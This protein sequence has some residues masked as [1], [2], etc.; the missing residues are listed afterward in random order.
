MKTVGE[1]INRLSMRSLTAYLHEILP[2]L[3]ES[4]LF[5][6]QHFGLAFEGFQKTMKTLT[7][8]A[9]AES[10]LTLEDERNTLLETILDAIDDGMNNI[11]DDWAGEL[12]QFGLTVEDAL[13]RIPERVAANNLLP[14][15]EHGYPIFPTDQSTLGHVWEESE[16]ALL[17]QKLKD[18]ATVN[19]QV[20]LGIRQEVLDLITTEKRVT[21]L[22]RKHHLESTMAEL[23]KHRWVLAFFYSMSTLSV[24]E[25][26][27]F[28][29]RTNIRDHLLLVSD[30][31]DAF[32]ANQ[33]FL[34]FSPNDFS[35]TQLDE[36]V[37]Q[38]IQQSGHE[39]LK[40]M[41]E[42][43]MRNHFEQFR[44]MLSL[45]KALP[46]W[47]EFEKAETELYRTFELFY[48][49]LNHHM[50][51]WVVDMEEEEKLGFEKRERIQ[52]A[53]DILNA[54]IDAQALCNGLRGMRF[55]NSDIEKFIA[56]LAQPVL[57]NRMGELGLLTYYEAVCQAQQTT[58][59]L[60]G[61]TMKEEL[62]TFRDIRE[63][64]TLF[65]MFISHCSKDE[66]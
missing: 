22:L 63:R 37:K 47:S 26:N 53:E 34:R 6:S 48:L 19:D 44:H 49:T 10:I 40:D 9:A 52:C 45:F 38:I 65:I 33:E 41:W 61:K 12:Q 46:C 28:Y 60:V 57:Q 15:D 2:E 23:H 3:E 64:V 13:A 31:V 30:E 62:I 36:I 56:I 7:E 18:P 55:T 4:P 50:D 20:F 14:L 58:F 42:K 29:K 54:F 27:H 21:E 51:S 35:L 24:T 66:M 25:L 16:Y 11:V 5:N 59:A 43:Y 39:F 8:S 1:N 32:Y 17:L